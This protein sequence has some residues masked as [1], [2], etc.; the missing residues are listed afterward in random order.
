MHDIVGIDDADI[1][2]SAAVRSI[3]MRSGRP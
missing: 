1:S 3:A 2:A